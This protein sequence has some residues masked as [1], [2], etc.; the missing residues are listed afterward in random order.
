MDKKVAVVVGG[1]GGIGS[2][3][4]KALQKKGMTVCFTYH[5]NKK[6]AE[7]LESSCA[8][9]IGYAMDVMDERSVRGVFGKILTRHAGIHVVVYSVVSPITNK[10]ILATNWNDHE[11]HYR[12]QVKGFWDVVQTLKEPIQTKKGLKFVVIA[13]EYCIGKPPAGLSHYVQAKYALLGLAK[14][15]VADLGRYQCTVNVIA[16]G[17]VDTPLLA[18]LPSKLIEM[19]AENNPLKRI[20]TPEDVANVV[21]FLSDDASGYLNGA[22]VTVNGGSTLL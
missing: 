3:V 12:M 15:M 11:D 16:P 10:N 7:E 19:T 22:L 2:A 8:G 21:A 4:V 1:S 17:M 9:A 5:R 18:P 14:A 20:A 6:T 13:T